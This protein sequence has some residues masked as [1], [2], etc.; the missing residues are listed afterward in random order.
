M[1]P[2]I[3]AQ[4]VQPLNNHTYH[5]Q[6]KYLPLEGAHLRYSTSVPSSLFPITHGINISFSNDREAPQPY[7]MEHDA[8]SEL[9]KRSDEL[10]FPPGNVSH[11]PLVQPPS[12]I[13]L[14]LVLPQ[15]YR[16][17]LPYQSLNKM[18][19]ECFDILLHSD[20]NATVSAPTGCGKTLLFELAII[21]MLMHRDGFLHT[22]GSASTNHRFGKIVYLSPLRSLANEIQQ[23]WTAK[24]QQAG[25][26]VK[27]LTGDDNLYDSSSTLSSED[28]VGNSEK[29]QAAHL[30]NAK[31]RNHWF[32]IV[33][34]GDIIVT[35]PEK[36]DA[37][38]RR[39]VLNRFCSMSI[40]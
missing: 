32:N 21:R 6:S 10:Y 9:M 1:S 13:D 28:V 30:E 38:T 29:G 20:K 31:F 34:S 7:G 27:C 5:Q 19:S 11:A 14:D 18:Q 25:L 24:F 15:Q 33:T 12:G 3:L 22:P 23:N 39:Y 26:V 37:I 8:H 17:L 2:Q 35:T 40:S 36:W 4:D 16:R